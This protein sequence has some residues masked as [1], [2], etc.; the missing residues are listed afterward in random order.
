MRRSKIA[1]MGFYVPERVVTNDE[2][3]KW[4]TT[5][6]E[7]IQQRTGIKERR[8]AADGE[9]VS[10]MAQKATEKC[11]EDAGKKPEDIDFIILATLSPDHCF[12]ASSQFLQGYLDI[13]PTP[14]V[15]V[16]AQ[17]SGFLYAL[18]LADQCVRT[19][20]YDNVLVIGA[21]NHSTGLE[22]N[23]RG[24][25]V[26]VIFGDGAG[27]FLLSAAEEGDKSHIIMNSHLYADGKYAKKLWTDYPASCE[28]PR[29]S[30]EGLDQGR[31]YPQM[32]GKFVFK[33]AVTRMPEVI[34][35]ALDTAG[36]T[37]DDLDMLVPHQANLRIN[38][39]VAKQLGLPPEKM[40]NNIMY[41]GNTTAATIPIGMCEVRDK[42][43]IKDG[44]LV[45]LAAFGA[46]F[47]WG[48][49]LVKW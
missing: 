13:P 15:D 17:C 26:T 44:D 12:P 21:E 9:G 39:F 38:E 2:L 28:M 48:A 5:S 24:R 30:H 35:E 29:L 49:T 46:G 42:G 20:L 16:H 1:G 45:C 40:Y 6:D 19:G 7:W 32:D 31:H 3:T 37:I 43:L 22:Y 11:L 10:H 4:L 34:R 41:Y 18:T 33:H 23:D 14:A 25:S 27:A 8:Y 47:T 36:Y